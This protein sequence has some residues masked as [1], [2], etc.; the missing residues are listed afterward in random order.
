VMV[1][2]QNVGIR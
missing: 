1:L 2:P